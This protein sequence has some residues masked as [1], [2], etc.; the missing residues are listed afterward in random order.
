[1]RTKLFSLFIIFFFQ[2]LILNSAFSQAF[3]RTYG[4]TRS[5]TGT[6]IQQTLDGNY[7]ISGMAGSFTNGYNDAYLLKIDP[8]G[9]LLWSKTYGGTGNEYCYY[10]STCTDGGFIMTG[11]TDS[12]SSGNGD[13][14]LIKTDSDGNHQWSA[15]V[16][17]TGGDYGWYVLQADDGGFIVSGFSN[18]FGNGSWDGYIVKTNSAGTL[19]WTKVFAGTGGDELYGMNKTKDNGYIITGKTSTN[20]FG[21]SDIWLIKLNSNGDTTWTRQYG[22]A[23]EDAGNAVKQTKDGG[24]I[25]AGDSH[26]YANLGAHRA[27]LVKTDSLGEMQWAKVF[28]SFPGSEVAYDV[29]QDSAN[30]YYVL[31]TTGNFGNG[32]L[33]IFL[34]RTDSIGGLKWA[35]TYGNTGNDDAWL[36]QQTSD[37]GFIIVAATS[38]FGAGQFDVYV[39]RTDSS[40]VTVCNDTRPDPL[41]TIAPLLDT[42]WSAMISGGTGVNFA[43]TVT[44]ANT[45]TFDPCLVSIEETNSS[46]VEVNVY[47]NPSNGKIQVAV[48]G[49]SGSQYKSNSYRIEIYNAFGEK[50]YRSLITENLLP[51]TINLSD[52][53]C[54]IYFYK[55]ES[56]DETI[57]TGK[58][59]IE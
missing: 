44:N 53:P 25:I 40:N 12:L 59:I 17:G 46:D 24:Y 16:G 56:S 49:S 9:N 58:L 39:I 4:G 47:P 23:T 8:T 35:K 28:G 48:A 22:K 1:M 2:F 19:Q 45:Q 27:A 54:G 10:V 30:G 29:I 41:D 50:V 26:T 38:S 7:I 43:I 6:C 3:Q 31:G 52:K 36:F 33:D 57:A 18:S 15:T 14:F 51:I 5:E 34:V 20:S 55:V 37:G 42:T 11:S 21:S 13:L 32:G